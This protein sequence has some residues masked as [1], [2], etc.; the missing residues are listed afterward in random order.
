[1]ATFNTITKLGDLETIAF[2][3]PTPL[4][5]GAAYD[6]AERVV[7]DVADEV[8]QV[9]VNAADSGL[10]SDPYV[11]VFLLGQIGGDPAT[12]A[13]ATWV[14]RIRVASGGGE[15]RMNPLALSHVFG[16]VLP[17]AYK[18]R[19]FNATGDALEATGH[20]I[21]VRTATVETRKV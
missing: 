16:G 6:S 14:G 8:V 12:T 3:P 5:N 20:S 10:D 2:A 11:D 13:N 7:G 21:T 17:T 15:A 18:L 4:A 9:T 19:L 1:M